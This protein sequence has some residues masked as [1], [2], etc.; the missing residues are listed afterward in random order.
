[1]AKLSATEEQRCYRA[2]RD[3][4]PAKREEYLKKERLAW[5]KKK[6]VGKEDYK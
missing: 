2:R 1:M 3:G 5:Q 6:S 4:N